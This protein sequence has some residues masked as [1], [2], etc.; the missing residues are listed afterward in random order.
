MQTFLEK[1]NIY[2][3]ILINFFYKN[4]V[5]NIQIFN[6]IEQ[7]QIIGPDSLSI[8]LLTAFFIGLVF[9]IQIVKEFLSLNAINAVGS[10]L[11]IS[12][13][14]E[15]SPV[16]TSIIL[17]GRIGSYFTS[18][19]ATMKITEQID[20]LYLLDISPFYYLVLP[21]IL[22]FIIIIPLLNIIS[23]ITSLLSSL[24]ICFIVYN[25]DSHIFINSSIKSLY[26][27]DIIKSSIKSIIFGFFISLISCF[28]GLNSYGGSKGV[29]ISTTISVVTSL[30]CIFV[31]DFCLSYYMFDYLDSS[32]V[33]SY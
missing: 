10:V 32:F 24:F 14:R 20:V 1:S 28:C 29:G 3:K 30:L 8:I 11:T 26:F 33:I 31:L 22:A 6:I 21:R 25:I 23:F 18:E 27:L 12:F 4:K 9:S 5:S 17:I 19:I 16:L 13:L 2:I 15:L 7:M